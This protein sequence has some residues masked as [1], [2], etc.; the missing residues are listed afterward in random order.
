MLEVTSQWYNLHAQS[1]LPKIQINKT[2][3]ENKDD[4]KPF[5][6][7]SQFLKINRKINIKCQIWIKE[8]LL[9]ICDLSTHITHFTYITSYNRPNYPTEY[10]WV[11][12]VKKINKGWSHNHQVNGPM[13]TI[14]NQGFYTW[15]ASKA[16]CFKKSKV[17]AMEDKE[18]SK[19]VEV[20]SKVKKREYQMQSN[21]VQH[22]QTK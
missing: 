4:N 12:Q 16:W 9:K 2:S 5:L 22:K 3:N 21:N 19:W 17:S 1:I 18:A 15:F 6:Q 8:K 7:S 20:T 13:N 14:M 10:L 11:D